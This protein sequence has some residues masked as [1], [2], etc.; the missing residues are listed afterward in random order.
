MMENAEQALQ[1]ME[2]YIRAAVQA[3]VGNC[4]KLLYGSLGYELEDVMQDARI[5]AWRA[6][7]RYRPTG[8]QPSTVVFASV[9]NR[10]LDLLSLAHN[11]GR[12]QLWQL[13]DSCRDT[14]NEELPFVAGADSSPDYMTELALLEE[15]LAGMPDRL[16]QVVDYESGDTAIPLGIT[17]RHRN[18]LKSRVR[19]IIVAGG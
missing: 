2:P 5:C 13:P 15:R 16:R 18:R 6:L 14:Q 9:R 11:S 8:A 17:K 10:C 4:L 1:K 12:T 19:S 7:Q 3:T